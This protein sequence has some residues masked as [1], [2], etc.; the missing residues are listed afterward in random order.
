MVRKPEERLTTMETGTIWMCYEPLGSFPCC[1]SSASLACASASSQS[2]GDRFSTAAA[3][4]ILKKVS[5]GRPR[6]LKART[7]AF[8]LGVEGA[9]AQHSMMEQVSKCGCCEEV[10]SDTLYQSIHHAPQGGHH[11]I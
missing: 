7:V 4:L 9:M 6:K 11:G 5:S 1:T 8:F 3:A 10:S 2:R